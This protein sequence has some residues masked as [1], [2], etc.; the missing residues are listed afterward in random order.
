MRT[1]KD[2]IKPNGINL[3]DVNSEE[4]RQV[5]IEWINELD[6]GDGYYFYEPSEDENG[7][8]FLTEGH[9]DAIIQFIMHFFNITDEDLKTASPKDLPPLDK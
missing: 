6:M 8:S 2:L 9:D 7:I 4:L 3:S 5:A 1:L